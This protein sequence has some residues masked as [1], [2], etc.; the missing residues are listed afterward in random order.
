MN[1]IT[2]EETTNGFYFEDLQEAIEATTETGNPCKICLDYIG[3]AN[4]ETGEIDKYN[5]FYCIITIL[6]TPDELK[7]IENAL[8][9][10]GE[11]PKNENN[12]FLEVIDTSSATH[13]EEIIKIIL[14]AA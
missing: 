11:E 3:S 14:N 5:A 13:T 10:A 9:E 1:N 12:D 8:I 7:K 4:P 6:A 2:R